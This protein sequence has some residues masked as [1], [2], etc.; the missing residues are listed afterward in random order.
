MTDRQDKPE[1]RPDLEEAR[2]AIRSLGEKVMKD[3]PPDERL[4]R[5]IARLGAGE[6]K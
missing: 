5:A 6:E 1:T 4:A 3:L 2:I